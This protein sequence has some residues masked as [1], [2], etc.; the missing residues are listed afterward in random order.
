M[1]IIY[2]ILFSRILFGNNG[3][4][5]RPNYNGN[6]NPPNINP[7][8]HR[9][10]ESHIYHFYLNVQM[11]EL[12]GLCAIFSS[13]LGLTWYRI[14]SSLMKNL[15]KIINREKNG[16]NSRRLQL[17]KHRL[18]LEKSRLQLEKINF[19]P[20]TSERRRI[21]LLVSGTFFLSDPYFLGWADIHIQSQSL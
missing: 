15:K 4:S 10:Q 19:S 12:A 2:F 6:Y 13:N 11:V 8:F 9:L 16:K 1:Y 7:G 20:R 17:E 18:Y 14:M 5:T 3:Q 21:P